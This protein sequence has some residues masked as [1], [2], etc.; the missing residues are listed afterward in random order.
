MAVIMPSPNPRE[1]RIMVIMKEKARDLV[2]RSSGGV[3]GWVRTSQTSPKVGTTAVP[4][5]IPYH[6]A[7]IREPGSIEPRS[8]RPQSRSYHLFTLLLNRA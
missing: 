1:S 7:S 6:H 4:T 3:K 2:A 5:L 8:N